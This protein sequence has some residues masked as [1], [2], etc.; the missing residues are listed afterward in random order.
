MADND[1]KNGIETEALFG[2][3][4][5]GKQDSTETPMMRAKEMMKNDL[6]KRFYK[7]VS[8]GEEGGSFQVLLDGRSIKS[9]AK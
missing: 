9:P 7:E 1:K 6:P 2:D 8:I 5:P 4:V 3:F